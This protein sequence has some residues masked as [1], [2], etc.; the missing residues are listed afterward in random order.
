MPKILFL[1]FSIFFTTYSI[2]DDMVIKVVPLN[3]RFAPE[4]QPLISPLL[5]NSEYL[6]A[7]GASLI[8]K[9]TPAR[10]NELRKLIEQLDK[11]LSNLTITIIQSN[12]KTADSLNASANIRVGTSQ[13]NKSSLSRRLRGRFADAKKSSYSESQQQ[14]QTLD[15]KAAF[16]KTGKIH[17]IHNISIHSS[18]IGYTSVSSNTQ[19]IEASTGFLVTPRL[20]GSQVI[21]EVS[22][23]SD[24]MQ[25]SGVLST[26]RSHS[27]IRVNLGEWVEIGGINEQS[28]SSATRNLSHSYSTRQKKIRI[29]IKIDATH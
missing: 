26:Q 2:A 27:T 16:I 20:S 9:A 28:Q 5:E 19:Y 11:K 13:L 14:I 23:W 10:Q 29:L 15:G 12:S 24:K 1:F 17:P 3:N 7:N 25:N 8:I 21:L 22:P 6:I 18:P 4:L